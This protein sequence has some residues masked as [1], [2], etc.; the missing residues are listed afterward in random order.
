MSVLGSLSNI[1][2]PPVCLPKK[3]TIKYTPVPSPAPLRKQ[4][5]IPAIISAITDFHLFFLITSNSMYIIIQTKQYLDKCCVM[6][7]NYNMKIKEII[8]I[9]EKD[10]WFLAAQKGSH[11]QFKH[12]EKKGRVTIAGKLS[13]DLAAGTLNS[14]FKQAGLKEV[15]NG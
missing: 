15:Q 7:Y 9:I 3:S 13:S 14:I 8:K 11:R 1:E 4:N 12:L 6:V 2:I 10:G 5:K